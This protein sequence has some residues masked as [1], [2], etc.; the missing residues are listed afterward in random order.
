MIRKKKFIIITVLAV[1]CVIIAVWSI[2]RYNAKHELVE[3]FNSDLASRFDDIM[4]STSPL[5]DNYATAM[6]G[7][8]DSIDAIARRAKADNDRAYSDGFSILWEQYLRTPVA[9]ECLYIMSEYEYL[10]LSPVYQMLTNS[11]DRRREEAD[12]LQKMSRVGVML[13]EPYFLDY[14]S[15]ISV[16]K[17][18]RQYIADCLKV[19]EPYRSKQTDVRGWRQITPQKYFKMFEKYNQK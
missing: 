6:V 5:I 7:R 8:A 16:S 17:T 9:G 15:V 19:M 13:K 4:E 11:G 12:A 2:M 10:K 1:C 14:D 3:Q 18:A